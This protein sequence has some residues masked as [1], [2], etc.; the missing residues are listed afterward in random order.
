MQKTQACHAQISDK[1]GTLMSAN[2][3][4]GTTDEMD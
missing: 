4:V 2:V 1:N 3:V